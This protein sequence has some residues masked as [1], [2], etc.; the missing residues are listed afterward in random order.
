[1]GRDILPNATIGCLMTKAPHNQLHGRPPAAPCAY[2]ASEAS[3]FT[4]A[5]SL[6]PAALPAA[7]RTHPPRSDRQG[8]RKEGAS[9]VRQF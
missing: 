9:G 7:K 5:G 8:C 1:V 4:T 3:N 6:C 2:S